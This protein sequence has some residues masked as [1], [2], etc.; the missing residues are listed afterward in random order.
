MSKENVAKFLS[1]AGQAEREAIARAAA[2]AEDPAVTVAAIVSVASEQGEGFTAEEFVEVMT[3]VKRE[4]DQE[5]SPEDL[6]GVVGGVQQARAAM[7]GFSSQRIMGAAT[8]IFEATGVPSG[9]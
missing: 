4:L 2:G 1:R 8:E 9:G 3:S 7:M 5:L 6:A